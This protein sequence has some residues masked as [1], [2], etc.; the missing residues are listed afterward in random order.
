MPKP[1]RP[2]A[3]VIVA[4]GIVEWPY[5][6]CETTPQLSASIPICILWFPVRRWKPF[7]RSTSLGMGWRALRSSYV[8]DTGITLRPM[9]DTGAPKP[10]LRRDDRALARTAKRSG[11]QDAFVKRSCEDCQCGESDSCRAT[12]EGALRFI[13]NPKA[14]FTDYRYKRRAQQQLRRLTRDPRTTPNCN[15]SFELVLRPRVWPS[16]IDPNQ[17][18]T[19]SYEL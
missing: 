7:S 17:S 2:F 9:R 8:S 6:Q 15:S 10:V 4:F 14:N 3:V 11:E 18:W 16:R 1:D 19:I 5:S 13:L 12:C